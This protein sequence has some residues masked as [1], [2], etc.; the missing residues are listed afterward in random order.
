MKFDYDINNYEVKELE[1]IFDLP[2]GYTEDIISSN[3]LKLRNSITT[4]KTID[5]TVKMQTLSFLTDAKNILLANS[6]NPTMAVSTIS[7]KQPITSI[8][9]YIVNHP[10]EYFPIPQ[11]PVKKKTRTISL[12]IDTK[13]R[14]EYYV[15]QATNFNLVLPMKLNSVISM[16][17]GAIEMPRTAYFAV[18][19]ALGNNFIW[20]SV[21][22]QI[23][24]DFS[25]NMI[26]YKAYSTRLTLPDGNFTGDEC[27]SIFN[28]YLTNIP[29][30]YDPPEKDNL[31]QYVKFAVTSSSGTTSGSNGS[32]QLIAYIDLNLWD[33][34]GADVGIST[35]PLFNFV[36]DMQAD[37][38]GYTDYYTPLPL[39]LGWNLGYR[40]G[41]YVNNSSYISEGSVNLNGPNYF[42]ICIDD[43]NNATDNIYAIL[44]DSILSKNILA[45]SAIQS[46][47]GG[48]V[49]YSNIGLTASPR[50]YP[51]PVDIERLHIQILDAYGRN[52]N[53]LNMDFSFVLT[54]TMNAGDGP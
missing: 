24:P 27:I 45:R 53:L 13:F 7:K 54:F 30:A 36:I 1:N 48:A 21:P 40:N 31:L 47:A 51:G 46:S 18:T 16:Q 5:Y 25:G 20:L 17:L 3:E 2:E 29:T 4:D 26:T 14:Q 22:E 49:G 23:A 11:N 33:P 10:E 6:K 52:L 32:S 19:E 15:T 43:Y 34:S 37:K 44:T 12:S 38:N 42:Y 8:P 41:L 28:K 50:T 39:K 35:K 9:K